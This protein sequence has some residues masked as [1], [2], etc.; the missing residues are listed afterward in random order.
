MMDIKAILFDK[1]GTLF[2]FAA[3][4]EAWAESFLLRF[5]NGDRIRAAEIGQKIGFDLTDKRFDADSVVIAGTPG[6]VAEALAPHVPDIPI[7]KIVDLLNEEAALA[8]QVPAVP[9]MPFLSG[10]RAQGLRLGVATNDAIA[11]ARA[12]LAAAKIAEMFDFVAGY[13]SG[14]GAKPAPGPLLAFANHIDVPPAQIVMV[15]DSTHDLH[16][17]RAAGMR[18]VGVLTGTAPAPDLEPLADI[19]LPD[20]GH[21][22]EWLGSA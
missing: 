3:T 11:P 6:Q 21:L 4:W 2:D 8:T 12:H 16:A 9:L 14:Y 1:D 5:C 18:S 19:V 15:G 7:N 17:A 13:D 10:L 20:I 22:Q